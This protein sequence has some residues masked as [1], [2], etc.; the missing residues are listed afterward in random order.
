MFA[1]LSAAG[2]QVATLT[3]P[4]ITRLVPLARPL[5]PRVAALNHRIRAA[6]LRHGVVVA[7]TADH[8]V[9]T[10]PRLW[11]EDR[12][13]ASPLGHARI[14]AAMA[15]AL[16]QPGSD[17][18]WAHPLPDPAPLSGHRWHAVADELRW[19]VTFLGPWIARRLRG[20]SSGDSRTAKRPR[21][22]AVEDTTTD[23]PLTFE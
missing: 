6:A 19:A 4:D 14:S 21:L 12:L 18:S 22:L 13:H 2:A 9:V 20:R 15:H 8:P 17:D 10:D 3:F 7:E 16:A 23:C 1:D 11:S 5:S